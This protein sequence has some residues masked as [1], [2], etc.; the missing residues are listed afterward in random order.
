MATIGK[1][2]KTSIAVITQQ[3]PFQ[4]GTRWQYTELFHPYRSLKPFL[5]SLPINHV[6]N[7]TKVL[8]LPVL[9]L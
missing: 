5:S 6:P 9:I 3:I 8:R 1:E 2:F 4:S 7:S